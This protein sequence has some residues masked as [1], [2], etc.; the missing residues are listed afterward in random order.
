MEIYE[1]YLKLI[2]QLLFTH[3]FAVRVTNK[4]NHRDTNIV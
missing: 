2:Y 4:F 3:I 1:A